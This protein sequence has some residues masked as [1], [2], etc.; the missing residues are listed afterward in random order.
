MAGGIFL[1][2]LR[3]YEKDDA[4]SIVSWIKD[5]TSFRKWCADRYDTY[6]IY[7]RDIQNHYAAMAGSDFFFPMTAYD[8]SGI[9][10][11]LIIRF[12]DESKT[13]ARFGFVIVDDAKRGRGYGKEMLRLSIEYTFRMPQVQ[14]ITLGVFENNSSAHYCY[15]AVG[16]T[17]VPKKEE[18]YYPILGSKWKCLEM[19]MERLAKNAREN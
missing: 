17:D 7:P 3:P 18:V 10:G 2:R 5:E 9:V 14:R 11:H 6:P 15:K 8:E 13:E 19:V 4:A 12:T 16:F 1:L